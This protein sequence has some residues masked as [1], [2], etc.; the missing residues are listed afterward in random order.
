MTNHATTVSSGTAGVDR[1]RA[2]ISASAGSFGHFM[3]RLVFFVVCTA[4]LITV[5]DAYATPGQAAESSGIDE[6]IVETQEFAPPVL[7]TIPTEGYISSIFGMRRLF[8]TTKAKLHKGI[9]IA[10]RRGT[11]VHAAAPGMILFAGHLPYYG[12]IVEIDHGNGF[13]TRYAHL[14]RYVVKKNDKVSSGSEIGTVGKTGR[15]TGAHLHFETLVSGSPVDPLTAEIWQLDKFG[16]LK[17]EL[18]QKP[19][20]PLVLSPYL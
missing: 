6:K 4:L 1:L 16:K 12:N 9:D 8:S 15:A 13:V 20:T 5:H 2:Y 19:F 14:D 17:A 11:P 18:V 7:S 10:A 3:H